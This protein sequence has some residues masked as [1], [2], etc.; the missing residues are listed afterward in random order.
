MYIAD[1]E[2]LQFVRKDFSI[3]LRISARTREMPNID[4]KLDL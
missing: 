4:D 3:E 2:A 1:L